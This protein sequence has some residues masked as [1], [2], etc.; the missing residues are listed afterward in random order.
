MSRR[1]RITALIV[2]CALFMQNLDSTVV[3]TALPA[4]ARAFHTPPVHMNVALTS[5]LLSLTVFIPA[6]GWIADRYGSRS[7]FRM[8]IAIFTFGS[9]LCGRAD[10]LMFLVFARVLQGVGG[11]LMVPVGRLLLLRSVAK[12][13]YVA[14]MAWLSVPAMLGPVLGPPVGGFIVTY[15]SWSWIF[16]IN[17]PIGVLGIVLVSLYIEDTRDQPAGGFDWIGLIL[18]AITMVGLMFGLEMASRGVLPWQVTLGMVVAGAIAAVLYFLHARVREHPLLDLS[19]MR[20]PTFGLSVAAASFFRVGIGATPFLLPLMLQLGFGYS[21]AGSGVITFASSAGALVMKTA[22]QY[23]L[24]RF[25]FRPTLIYNGIISVASLGL[26]AAF[27]PAWP[28][29]AIYAVLLL[30]GFFRSLQFTAFNTIAFADISGARMSQATS[31]YSTAQ[32]LSLAVG[33]AAGAA[34]LEIAVTLSGHQRPLLVDYSFAFLAVAVVAAISVP[35]SLQFSPDA[36]AEVSGQRR[37]LG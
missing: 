6:S 5:Y 29:A 32:Q 17:V 23:A 21:A 19:L 26:M 12:T 2:A 7:V 11:A 3:A 18:V 24:R 37:R 9:V 35:I 27:R 8:A 20:I 16:D 22:A 15:A 10:S 33:V 31:F 34:A 13:E 14:A 25:G 1:A 4:M 30:G 28:L 36:G